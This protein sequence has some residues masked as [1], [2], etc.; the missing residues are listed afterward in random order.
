MMETEVFFL[1][2]CGIG[3]CLV[4]DVSGQYIGSIFMC[5]AVEEMFFDCLTLEFGTN[6]SSRNACNS[7]TT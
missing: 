4:A 2:G 1:L 3:W 7:K 6:I 5:Q